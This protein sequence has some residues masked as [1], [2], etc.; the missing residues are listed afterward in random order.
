MNFA[1]LL[2]LVMLA[3]MGWFSYKESRSLAEKDRWVSHSRDVLDLSESLRSHFTA[4]GAARHA[5]VTEGDPA[6]VRVFDSESSAALAIFTDLRRSV[7][8]NPTQEVRVT[9]LEVAVRA[10][11]S[12]FEKSIELHERMANDE[13]GQEAISEEGVNL[14]THAVDELRIFEDVERGLLQQRVAEAE[15]IDRRATRINEFL[16]LSVFLFL[17]LGVW[18]VN[19]EL[20][21][22]SRAEIATGKERKLLESILNSCSDVVVVADEKGKII[23]RNPAADRLYRKG[24]G[25]ELTGNNSQS[26]GMYREN[27][28]P[29]AHEE[30]PLVRAVRGESVEALELCVRHSGNSECRYFLAAGAPLLD[31]RGNRRGGVIF[32]RDIT[33][34]KLD[35][36]RLA[37]ALIE[38][39]RVTHERSELAKLTDLFQSCHG[40]EEA[41]K[42]VNTLSFGIFDSR[43]GMLCLTNASRNLVESCASWGNCS[44]SKEVFEPSECWGLRQ[45]KPYVGGDAT[46]LLRCP[47]V[48]ELGAGYLCVPL[49]A[50]GETYGVL[51]VE[52][53]A[54]PLGSSIEAA[55]TQLKQFQSLA[56]A[57]A[58][59]IS[60]AV[61]NLR[62][63]EVLRDQSIQ[64]PLTGLFNRRYL[65]ESLDREV[66][67]ASRA[68]RSVA[69]VML[70]IDH[71]K[72]FNDTFGHQ[73][74]DMILREVAAVFKARVRA[75]DLACRYGGEEF[76]LV[77][78][79]TDAE[80]A[81]ACIEKI[82]E[83]I[84]QLSVEFRGQSLGT[85]TISAGIAVFPKHSD[86]SEGLIHIADLALYRAK[87]EG[88]NRVVVSE[89]PEAV[90]TPA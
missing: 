46:A 41:C 14:T 10:R 19:R 49:A 21:R 54:V 33:E 70:D 17:I 30:L 81:R 66:H 80:G 89:Q 77:L 2:V 29:F 40:V 5:Y 57:V 62:L 36:G 34:R 69:L 79:E 71:F 13:Q 72:Q 78:A 56:T 58:E 12:L 47:H 24:P 18:I 4:A 1:I 27:G 85:V 28:E 11:V 43:P 63:R 6:Q 55:A 73:S 61:A 9:E 60:S 35:S 82:R 37:A 65:E 23:L 64:D 67:R 52:N 84:K 48:I 88:R 74:G 3:T 32:L 26:L 44:T 45:G 59:R 83:A 8:D 38:S 86:N 53:K 68:Q 50:Q 7:A 25:E 90:S 31:T 51:Y 15:S 75:G 16:G 39:E 76:A 20:S 42:V 22:R 87:K